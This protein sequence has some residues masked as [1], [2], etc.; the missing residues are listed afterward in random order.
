[1]KKWIS[2]TVVVLAI[3][4]SFFSGIVIGKKHNDNAYLKLMEKTRNETTA[5]ELAMQLKVLRGIRSNSTG[6]AIDLLEKWVDLN[7]CE[8]ASYKLSKNYVSNKD[9]SSAVNS[10][11]EYRKNIGY[12]VKPN[13]AS[14]VSKAFSLYSSNM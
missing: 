5:T 10:V 3:I 6:E 12:T 9:I 13:L 7:L 2:T 1:M 14:C 4:V 11:R 8:L